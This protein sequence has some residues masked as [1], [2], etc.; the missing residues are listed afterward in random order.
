MHKCSRNSVARETRSKLAN[1]AK[2]AHVEGKNKRKG[3]L[4]NRLRILRRA[5]S[6]LIAENA[7][8]EMPSD[9]PPVP[10]QVSLPSSLA[11]RSSSRTQLMLKLQQMLLRKYKSKPQLVLRLS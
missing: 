8:S 5:T 4:S 10:M 9:A 7:T 3:K 6:N 11:T 1:L 2:T